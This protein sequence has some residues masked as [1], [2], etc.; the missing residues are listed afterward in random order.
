MDE[1]GHRRPIF[2]VERKRRLQRL[3][4]GA[5]EM[6]PAVVRSAADL[7]MM[8]GR[9]PKVP[10]GTIADVAAGDPSAAASLCAGPVSFASIDGS[11]R[12]CVRAAR[13]G[14]AEIA[15]NAA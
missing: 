3:S 9:S 6:P 7:I 8:I 10:A 14:A 2:R 13:A 11:S 5:D 4:H 12:A 15:D 1:L